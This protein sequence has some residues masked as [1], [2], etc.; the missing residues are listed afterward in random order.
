MNKDASC[1]LKRQFFGWQHW[2]C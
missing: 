2:F 1:F